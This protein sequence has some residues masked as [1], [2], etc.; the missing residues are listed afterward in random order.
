MKRTA[1]LLGCVC[2][3]ASGCTV[4]PTDMFPKFTWYWSADAKQY[5]ADQHRYDYRNETN[6]IN[7]P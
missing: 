4:V 6:N 7:N 5:R 2:L 1:V 3:I